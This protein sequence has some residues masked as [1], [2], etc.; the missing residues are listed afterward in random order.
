V[1]LLVLVGL[2]EELVFRG[3]IQRSLGER[4]GAWPAILIAATLFGFGHVSPSATAPGDILWLVAQIGAGAS[5]AIVEFERY[6]SD[7]Y[8]QSCG[9]PCKRFQILL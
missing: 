2:A 9:R 3:T 5:S 7:D 6:R 4:L 8:T 1:T